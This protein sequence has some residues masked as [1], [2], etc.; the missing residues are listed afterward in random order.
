MSTGIT[1]SLFILEEGLGPMGE[2]KI[3][4]VYAVSS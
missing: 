4:L 3:A 2:R 1:S